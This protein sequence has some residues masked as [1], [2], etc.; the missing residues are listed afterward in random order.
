MD[1]P[2]LDPVFT[3]AWSCLTADRVEPDITAALAL[4]QRGLDAV[5]AQDHARL[6]FESVLTALD[7]ATEALDRSWNRVGHLDAVRNAPAL[8]AAY[9]AMLPKVT[10]FYT[11]ISLNEELWRVVRAYAATPEARTLKGARR[12]HL[13]ETV[14]SFRESGA[15]LSSEDKRE[16]ERL[17]AELAAATQKFSENVLD[18]TNAWDLV[19]TDEARLAGLPDSARAAARASYLQKHPE[20]ADQPGWRFTLHAPSYLPLMKHAVDDAL[21]RQAWEASANVGRRAPHDNTALTLKIIELRQAKGRLLGHP[22]FPD[23]VLRRRMA[24]SGASALAFIERMHHR[25]APAFARDQKELEAFKATRSGQPADRLEPWEATYWAEL[26]RQEEFHF[27]EEE[28]RPYLSIDGVLG[29]MFRLAERLFGVH[30]TE[31]PTVCLEPGASQEVSGGLVE[32][33]H[34]DVKFYEMHDLDGRHLGSFYAD[35]HPRENK[36]GGAWMHDLETGGPRANGRFAPHLGLIA[37]NL[38]APVAGQ[39]ALLMHDEVNTIFHEF[40]HLIHHLF[41]EVEIKAL[42]GVH[43]AWDFVELPSQILENWI[44]ERAGLDFFARHQVTGEPIPE[45]LFQKMH[46]ARN[47]L[48]ASALMRQLAFGKMDLDLHLHAAELAAQPS[49]DIEAWLRARLA[50]YTALYNTEPPTIA[51]KFTHLFA[52]P[53]GYAAG[54]YSYL[55]AEVLDADA[56]TRFQREG[57]LNPATGRDFREKILARG[58]SLPPEQLFRDFLGRDPDPE[59]LLVRCGLADRDTVST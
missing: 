15:D 52:S 36:R 38:T 55:W 35:W 24:K 50:T 47:Y 16:L 13:E 27:D 42:N 23:L 8:R 53:V 59:A 57:V 39:P 11:R 10:E 31:K 22:H 21:R 40:G 18:A 5:A 12:R 41:G 4:A 17:N 19:V 28:L 6:S 3:P 51:A 34:P 1:H 44:W 14:E 48:A 45:K 32:V 25:V 37:G 30:L 26:R 54:Y 33:W 2:F 43:V 7:D 49:P 56:F 58:N 20:G 29:G 9:N 46:A